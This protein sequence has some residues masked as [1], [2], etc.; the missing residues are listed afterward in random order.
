MRSTALPL[1]IITLAT[2]V[3]FLVGKAERSVQTSEASRHENSRQLDP[4]DLSEKAVLYDAPRQV[5]VEKFLVA[6]IHFVTRYSVLIALC[7]IATLCIFADLAKRMKS[8]TFGLVLGGL[9]FFCC[10]LLLLLSEHYLQIH[11]FLTTTAY[12]F[13]LLAFISWLASIII[14]FLKP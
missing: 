11:E 9:I 13:F 12:G 4:G 5:L 7:A 14:P 1:L 2:L 6:A 3:G 10:A 8:P